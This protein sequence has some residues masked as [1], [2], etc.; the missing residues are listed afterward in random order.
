MDQLDFNLNV[1]S[2]MLPFYKLNAIQI[3][4]LITAPLEYQAVNRNLK[5]TGSTKPLPLPLMTANP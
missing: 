3:F 5:D 1:I 4:L 2:I